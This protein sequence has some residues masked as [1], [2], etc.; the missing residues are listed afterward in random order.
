M[1]N[2]NIVIL[3]GGSGNDSLVKG[4]KKYYK[5]SNIKVIVNAYDNGKSTG[6]CR[7]VTNTLGVSD[8]RKNHIRMYKAISDCI[9]ARL[10]EFYEYRN[11]FSKE[12]VKDDIKNQLIN[13]DLSFLNIYV[14]HFF[15]NKLAN[16]VEYKDFSIANLVYSQMYKE[17]GYEAT[18]KY[19]CNLLELEDFVLLNSFDNVFI[20][21]ITQN[22]DIL[23]GEESIVEYKNPN[24]KIINIKYS[25]DKK[26]LNQKAID[27]IKQ[28][29]LIIISTGTFWSSIYP[30]LDYLDFYEYINESSAK[31]IWAINNTEDKDA[32]GVTS[33]DFITYLTKLGL[34]LNDFNILFNIDAI[35]TLKLVPTQFTNNA[36]FYSMENNNGKHNGLK[37]AKAILNI[38]YGL[39]NIE[40]YD[41]ILVDFDDTLWSR[42]SKII[43]NNRIYYN[44]NIS[45]ENIDLINSINKLTSVFIVSGNSYSSIKD[46][47]KTIYG[48]SI[49]NFEVG[50]WADSNSILYRKDK[51]E[52]EIKSFR[53]FDNDIIEVSGYINNLIRKKPINISNYCLKIKPLNEIER[54]LLL[55]T[56]NK[57]LFKRK[58]LVYLKAI[59]A[60]TTT[61]DIVHKNNTKGNLFNELNLP[62]KKCLY[63]GDEID[64]G[65]DRDIASLAYKSV[66]TSGV[67]ETNILLKLLLGE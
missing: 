10:V 57:I 22:S 49:N 23:I 65:N 1:D 34:N 44:D 43:K 29:D 67:E 45:R 5:N 41:Y 59:A 31:K 61:I 39:G 53:I 20:D 63:I 50:I 37:Y 35:D 28:A 6:I 54:S 42:K 26:E 27:A 62:S 12:T 9:D 60:G 48:S 17:L 8:I 2:L 52:E 46:K 55:E 7:K 56:L 15:E 40:D 38:Y 66:K 58:N 18:N 51:K 14:D 47:L 32:Y 4:L 64:S 13:W 19:F 24:N 36:Y 11:D 33:L 21:A 16:S 3:S 30:T 25:G